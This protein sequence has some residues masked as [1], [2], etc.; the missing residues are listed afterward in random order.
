MRSLCA[1]QPDIAI[2]PLGLGTQIEPD[3]MCE[4]IL[5]ISFMVPDFAFGMANMGMALKYEEEDEQACNPFQVGLSRLFC[6]IHCVRDAVI[7]GDRTIIRNLEK[8]TKISNDN[9]RL[10]PDNEL[11]ICSLLP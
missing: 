8:A 9:M 1:F 5:A 2:A 10:G 7:R 11:E 4:Q 6:D 3:V